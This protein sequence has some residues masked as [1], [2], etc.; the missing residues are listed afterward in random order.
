MKRAEQVLLLSL[1]KS[2]RTSIFLVNYSNENHCNTNSESEPGNSH[3]NA[4]QACFVQSA[5][6][7]VH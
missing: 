5:P 1:F 2:E 3:D 6:A 4:L 7:P